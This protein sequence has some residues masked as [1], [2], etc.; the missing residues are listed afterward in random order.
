MSRLIAKLGLC[1]LTVALSACSDGVRVDDG[2]ATTSLISN[3]TSNPAQA[4]VTGPVES[5]ALQPSTAGSR[6][7]NVDDVAAARFLNQA[8]FGAT[9]DSIQAFKA[10]GSRERWID[11]QIALPAS[12]TMP[13]TLQ[14]SN[15]SN[16]EARHEIWWNN[17]LDG[18]DQLRQRV[19]F[20]LSQIF[21]VSD[22]DATL[23]NAQYGISDYYD[24]LTNNAFANFRKLLEDVTLHPVM[25]VYLSMV[26]N[27]KAD[28][29]RRI[30]PDENYAREVLQLFSI[31]LFNLNT[32][33]EII[34]PNNP[35]PTYTQNT[36]EE[37]ARVFTG[38]DYP[39]SRRWDDTRLTNDFFL[40]RMVTN[41]NF[42]DT[43][44]KNLLNG[45]VVPAG[46]SAE[47]DMQAALDNIFQ[48][49]NVAPFISKQLIQRLV[50]SN[51]TPEYV[52]RVANVFNNNGGG[53][54]G[55]LAAVIKA[56]L[57]DTEA[58]N[59]FAN[60][61]NFGKLRE[62][63]IRLA[64]YWRVLDGQPG[65]RAEGVHSSADFPV[66][67]LDEMGGQAVMRSPSVFNFYLPD[68]PLVAG[69][70]LV[71]PEMQNMS[72]AF[73]AATS[74][75]YHHLVYRFHNRADLNNDNPRVTIT[76]F[77]ALAN[78]ASRPT[79]LIDWLDLQFYAGTMPDS[80]RNVLIQHMTSIPN[81]DAGRFARAQDTLFMVMVAPAT[82][83]QR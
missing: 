47:A 69:E 26:R 32:N 20:A 36:I 23:A 48:H 38:W 6:S 82:H 8:T 78:M 42:H 53:V 19:A 83:V 44:S 35:T 45:A 33:G 73:L 13:Y 34:N 49:Q 63:V 9:I 77:E 74:N 60:V 24:M 18:D 40:G 1:I 55:D 62:P 70:D 12:I 68:N 16:R 58:V 28:V 56:I 37:F 79:D 72:E 52:E 27:E 81:N 46:L 64:H 30:R 51:P 15:G 10:I 31:G 80:M 65:P 59:G 61:P 25:G 39:T 76:D 50:T 41:D 66:H 14:N 57:T 75:N 54:R 5:Q 71:S 11:A 67:R 7:F 3:S 43:G 2:S 22:Q 4:P 21:V 17:V 29:A